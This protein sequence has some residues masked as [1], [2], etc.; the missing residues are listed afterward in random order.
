M[1]MAAFVVAGSAACVTCVPAVSALVGKADPREV[2]MDEVAGQAVTFLAIPLLLP[3]DLPLQQCCLV[4]A[5]G[6]LFF[7][8]FDIFKPWPIRRLE[9]LPAGWGVLADDLLAGVFAAI[10]LCVCVRLWIA[11]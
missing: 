8:A 3:D 7:R 4:T 10:A 11:A 9:R 6:F 5:L 2:V 1:V